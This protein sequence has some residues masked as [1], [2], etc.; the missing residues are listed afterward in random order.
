MVPSDTIEHMTRALTCTGVGKLQQ[1]S[2][3]SCVSLG[4]KYRTIGSSPALLGHSAANF[5]M[6]RG[7][8]SIAEYR[9]LSPVI[10]ANA[11]HQAS[12][13]FNSTT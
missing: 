3:P 5:G 2:I 7:W 13:N 1:G 9:V 8:C 4:I 11:W 12:L 10:F 6:S